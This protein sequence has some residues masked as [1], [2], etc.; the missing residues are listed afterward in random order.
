MVLFFKLLNTRLYICFDITC[1]FS[2][3]GTY[4]LEVLLGIDNEQVLSFLISD[5]YSKL[6]KQLIGTLISMVVT[7]RIVQFVLF[8]QQTPKSYMLWV[9]LRETKTKQESSTLYPILL[10]D[11]MLSAIVSLK[12]NTSHVAARLRI[13]MII[14]FSIILI[15]KFQYKILQSIKKA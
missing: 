13:T 1:E 7:S 8:S 4:E 15:I 10:F 12:V 6:F 5:K 9:S 11:R 3:N 14:N 2:L